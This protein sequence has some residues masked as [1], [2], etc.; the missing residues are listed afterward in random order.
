MDW[1]LNELAAYAV[2]YPL[3]VLICIGVPILLAIF[4]AKM[5]R[6]G[7]GGDVSG[8]SVGGWDGDGGG[9]CG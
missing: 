2:A 7:I 6:S 4:V 1:F 8:G 9:D 5:A 3:T